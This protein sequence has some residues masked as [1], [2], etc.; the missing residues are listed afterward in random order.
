MGRQGNVR[1]DTDLI[2][3]LKQLV[4]K[5][6]DELGLKKYRSIS[7][8]TDVAIKKFLLEELGGVPAK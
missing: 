8:A 1:V 4:K 6:D 2:A 3:K 7:Q 5:K